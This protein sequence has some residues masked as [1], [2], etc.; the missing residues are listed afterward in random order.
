MVTHSSSAQFAA[1]IAATGSARISSSR[2]SG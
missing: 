1:A 2:I